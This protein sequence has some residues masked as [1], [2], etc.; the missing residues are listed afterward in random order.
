MNFEELSPEL[1]EKAKACTTP[2]ELKSL[3]EAEGFKLSDNM[4]EGVGG[5][6]VSDKCDNVG[7]DTNIC[8]EK[9]CYR[10]GCG[11]LHCGVLDCTDESCPSID[12]H[13]YISR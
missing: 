3:A 13:R 7:C 2:E 6:N 4:L 1:Q 11:N 10:V 12:C 8:G 5:G 9:D